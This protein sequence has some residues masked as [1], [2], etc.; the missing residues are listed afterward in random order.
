MQDYT[1]A[2]TASEI[3]LVFNGTAPSPTSGVIR[4]SYTL[5]KDGSVTSATDPRGNTTYVAN[6]E[7]GRPAVT[8]SPAT[9]RPRT[10]MTRRARS[11]RSGAV[12]SATRGR[13]CTPTWWASS[14]PQ[15]PR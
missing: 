14:R 1:K 3:E 9:A 10:C 7:L 13:T 5:D 2:L 4:T 8:T 11:S 6:D 15:G 12:P